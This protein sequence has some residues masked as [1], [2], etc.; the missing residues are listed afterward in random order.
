M[1]IET[2]YAGEQ[3][4]TGRLCPCSGWWICADEG[5]VLYGRRQ[6]FERGQ[7]MPPAVLLGR[8]TFWQWLTRQQPSFEIATVWTL[9]EYDQTDTLPM[10]I[11]DAV[12]A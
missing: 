7:R 2:V 1:M 5:R 3:T 4:A 11:E 6:R 12:Q 10:P 8:R 9:V